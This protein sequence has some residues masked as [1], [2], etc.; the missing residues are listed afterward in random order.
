MVSVV[1]K[2]CL[3]MLAYK[4]HL[5]TAEPRASMSSSG[6]YFLSVYYAN[7]ALWRLKKKNWKNIFWFETNRLHIFLQ[8]RIIQDEQRTVIWSM[9]QWRALLKPSYKGKRILLKEKRSSGVPSLYREAIASHWLHPRWEEES[10]F[11]LASVIVAGCES[12]PCWSPDSI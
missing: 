7:M 8:Q 11:L 5:A 2:F 12:I 9:Q 3:H 6:Q 1:G 4:H 10:F